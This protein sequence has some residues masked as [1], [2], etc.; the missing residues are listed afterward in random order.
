MAVEIDSRKDADIQAL[1]GMVEQA[2]GRLPQDVQH[3][4]N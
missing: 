1:F 2:K 4:K 3:L